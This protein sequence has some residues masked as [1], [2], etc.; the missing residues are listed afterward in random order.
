M[1]AERIASKQ[2][3]NSQQSTLE[4]KSS[5]DDIQKYP[6]CRGFTTQPGTDMLGPGLVQ[7]GTKCRDDSVSKAYT[8]ESTSSFNINPCGSFPVVVLQSE[9][10]TSFRYSRD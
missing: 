7:D 9:M 2:F 1:V 4:Q 6:P 10:C 8:E 5:F 3:V